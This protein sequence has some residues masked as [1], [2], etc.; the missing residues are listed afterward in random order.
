MT[1]IS[2]PGK[3]VLREEFTDLDFDEFEEFLIVEHIAF[4]EI[5]DHSGDFDLA[6]QKDMLAGLRHGT[7]GSRHDEDSAVHLRSAGDHIL[8]V[9]G[10]AGAVD[11]SVMAV[12]GLVFDVSDSDSDTALALFG[13]VIDA[14]KGGKV[15]TALQREHLSDRCGERGLAVIDMPNCADV[16]VR[17]GSFKSLLRHRFLP[18]PYETSLNVLQCA[19]AIGGRAR[20]CPY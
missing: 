1:G 20:R 17:L 13:S 14:V 15:S 2:S 6:S 19:Q 16:Y 11:V 8:D 7:V 12:I 9:V 10:V 4:I 18:Q 3:V 5:D